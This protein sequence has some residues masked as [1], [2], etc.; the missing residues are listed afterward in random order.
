MNE[1]TSMHR[2]FN[3][4]MRAVDLWTDRQ[5]MEHRSDA[6]NSIY[7]DSIVKFDS[8]HQYSLIKLVLCDE[9]DELE[10]FQEAF[11][12][13]DDQFPTDA[14]QNVNELR[15]LAA[16]AL[17]MTLED[18]DEESAILAT[19][20]L[21]ASC[22]SERKFLSDSAPLM[23]VAKETIEVC[24]VRFR[25]L[26]QEPDPVEQ[27]WVDLKETISALTGN[28]DVGKEF[29]QSI[30]DLIESQGSSI[31]ELIA[32]TKNHKNTIENLGEELDLLWWVFNGYSE[33]LNTKMSEIPEPLQAPLCGFEVAN[34]ISQVVEPPSLKALLS[35][36]I[37][38]S[39]KAF[40]ISDILNNATDVSRDLLSEKACPMITPI[41][42][43][44]T[45]FSED[46]EQWKIKWE[47]DTR[48][49]ADTEFDELA[50]AVQCCRERLILNVV[51]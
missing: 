4:W 44:L 12:E 49:N 30:A 46:K 6:V 2:Y 18:K 26:E 1:K 14:S 45:C 15:T 33:I 51:R 16:I 41:S 13:H 27:T 10:W 7:E 9:V 42:Y 23:S 32:I 40:S 17:A 37:A 11:I 43:A 36:A 31:N 47:K 50:L 3:E 48:L 28:I 21:T 5:S 29:F 34:K 8:E 39:A 35:R 19:E 38:R 22:F 24:A 25:D 20:I